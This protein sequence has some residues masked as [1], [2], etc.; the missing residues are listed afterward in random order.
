M[1]KVQEL[2]Y[3]L[4]RVRE[5]TAVRVLTAKLAEAF[6]RELTRQGKVVGF[7]RREWFEPSDLPKDA[8]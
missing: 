8:A 2:E 3:S 5:R 1:T 4:E 7:P 6:V